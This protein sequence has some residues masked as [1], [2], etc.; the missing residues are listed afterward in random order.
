MRAWFQRRSLSE[1]LVLIVS[2]WAVMVWSVPVPVIHL[3]T[4]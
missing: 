1:A 4:R 2:G 3:L